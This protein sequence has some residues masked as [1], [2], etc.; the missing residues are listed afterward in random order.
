MTKNDKHG[1][2]LNVTNKN[3]DKQKHYKS[4]FESFW[5]K[6]KKVIN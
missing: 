6:T 1:W 2:V 3:I 5:P 4:K